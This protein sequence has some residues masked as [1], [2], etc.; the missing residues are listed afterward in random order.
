MSMLIHYSFDTLFNFI[1]YLAQYVTT[2]IQCTISRRKAG[3]R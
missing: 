1:Y 2:I 3:L